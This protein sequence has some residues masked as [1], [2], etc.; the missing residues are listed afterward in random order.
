MLPSYPTLTETQQIYIIKCIKEYIDCN[1]KN[2]RIEDKVKVEDIYKFLEKREL[3]S[4]H[5]RYYDKRK[6]EEVIKNHY[7]TILC[8]ENE[9]VIGYGHIDYEERAWLGIC[10]LEGYQG[11]GYGKLIMNTLL[12]YIDERKIE[13][14]LTVDNDNIPAIELYLKYSFTITKKENNIL[15]MKREIVSV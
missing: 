12:K 15:W 14:Y 9:K 7:Y 11:R 1:V 13:V 4:K 5:F 8:Y 10:V 2:I 6:P 3:I